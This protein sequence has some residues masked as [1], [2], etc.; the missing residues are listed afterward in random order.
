MLAI[1]NNI[2]A[3]NAARYLGRSYDALAK[4]VERLSSGLRINSAKDDAAGM[5]VRELI[6]A[7]IGAIQQGSRN[8][9]DG[10]SMLQT[11]EGAVGQIGELLNRMKQLAEQAATGSYSTAQKDVMQA[12][13]AE[14]SAEIDR[15][16]TNTEFNGNTLLTVDQEDYVEIHIA[17]SETIGLESFNTSADGLGVDAT[18]GTKTTEVNKKIVDATDDDYID[19]GD[20]ADTNTITIGFDGDP[21]GV[22]SITVDLSDYAVVGITLAELVIEINNAVAIAAN[23]AEVEIWT[24]ASAVEDEVSGGYRLQLQAKDAGE[25]IFSIAT[26][27]ASVDFDELGDFTESITGED[28]G[29]LDITNAG[30]IETTL[31]AIDDAIVTVDEAR[32]SFGYK[33]NRLQ[34]SITVLD[35]QAENLSAAESRISDVDVATEMA[36]LTRNQVL[37]QAG[38]AMLAQ[39]NAIPQMALTLLRG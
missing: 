2:M 15:I 28:E 38:T 39:A 1:K 14:M 30:T 16:Q 32:A 13:F 8:A 33:M 7:D 22:D 4:S 10:I 34:S 31:D 21:A 23:T 27:T 25:S 12:E 6:R 19:G 29:G 9:Q 36:Q 11:M 20:I 18:N 24:M 37:A 5:A 17:S 3:A 35:I 26:T